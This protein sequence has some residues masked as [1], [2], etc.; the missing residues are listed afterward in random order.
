VG[1]GV[2]HTLFALANGVV[3]FEKKRGERSYVSVL[4]AEN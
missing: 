4:P 1:I 3:K 2:D